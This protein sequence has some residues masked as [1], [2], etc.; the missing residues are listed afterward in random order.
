[1]R[2]ILLIFITFLVSLSAARADVLVLV[3]GY[4][5]SSKSWH[6]PGIIAILNNAGYPLTGDYGFTPGG[7]VYRPLDKGSSTHKVYTVTLPSHAPMTIQSDWLAAYLRDIHAKHPDEAIVLAGHSA[8]GIAA[9]YTL[10]RHHPA[11]INRLITIAAPHLG[12][13]RAVQALDA[14]NNGGFFG[15]FREVIVKRQTGNALYNTVRSSRGV[16]LD[17]MPARPGNLL[18]WLNQQPHPDDVE[19]IS[20]IRTG[21]VRMPGDRVVPGFSQDLRNVG[22]LGQRAKSYVMAT[23]HLLSAKDG[24]LLVNLLK[25]K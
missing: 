11:G 3:H 15:K 6:E 8:G 24:H 18:Y 19:Y 2:S 22:A 4:L 21:T 16:L 10:I 5:G 9:R 7:V 14:T 12:T 1:M 25:M 13:Q 23:G 20:I 17:L